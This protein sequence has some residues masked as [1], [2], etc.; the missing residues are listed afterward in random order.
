MT[1]PENILEIQQSERVKRGPGKQGRNKHFEED[2]EN[3]SNEK[4]KTEKTLPLYCPVLSR[5][6]DRS[7]LFRV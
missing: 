4:D 5:V 6:F 2:R 3:S 7:H 1:S